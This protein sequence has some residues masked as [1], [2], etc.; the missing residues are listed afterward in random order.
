MKVTATMIGTTGDCAL[1][2][3]V[4]CL[5][6]RF[7]CEARAFDHPD[8]AIT[9]PSGTTPRHVVKA[10]GASTEDAIRALEAALDAQI[11][12]LRWVRWHFVADK[13]G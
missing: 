1:S 2:A 4:R 8:P 6:G 13:A 5:G 11:G 7:Y 9:I 12:P 10:E 3:V